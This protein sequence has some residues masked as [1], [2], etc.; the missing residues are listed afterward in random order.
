M[1]RSGLESCE[2]KYL[3]EPRALIIDEFHA[4]MSNVEKDRKW[5]IEH[6]LKT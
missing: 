6:R 1:Y 3:V 2:V 4:Q 5:S